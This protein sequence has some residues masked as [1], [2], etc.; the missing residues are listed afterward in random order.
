M[1]QSPRDNITFGKRFLRRYERWL[2]SQED[3][4]E[5]IAAAVAALDFAPATVDV[6]T[7]MY[8]DAVTI[9]VARTLTAKSHTLVKRDP[10]KAAALALLALRV[11]ESA[12]SPPEF[13]AGL[14]TAR[15]EAW[16]RY[17]AAVFETGNFPKAWRASERADMYFQLASPFPPAFRSETT[18]GLIQGMILHFLGETDRGL[19]RIEQSANLILAVFQEADKYVEAI[20]IYNAILM[21]A[22]RFEEAALRWQEIAALARKEGNSSTLA[23][24]VN[25]IGRCYL[26]LGKT[27]EALVC[28]KT[29]LEMF[30]QFG[31]LVEIPDVHLNLAYALRLNKRF[32]EAILEMYKCRADLAKFG[33]MFEAAQVS[34]RIVETQLLAHRDE[35]IP[36]VCREAADFFRLAGLPEEARRATECLLE[37]ART[38]TLRVEAVREISYLTQ[39]RDSPAKRGSASQ[40]GELRRDRWLRP[41]PRRPGWH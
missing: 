22:G 8:P 11:A 3:H 38:G 5:P 13:V 16:M 35:E 6:L 18:L 1:T 20:T 41:R 17:A 37:A 24:I 26:E 30:N 28:F 19:V 29:A 9:G 12:T 33:M 4:G 14:D 7:R 2:R 31:L 25:N 36:P 10:P 21:R 39:L 23:Y 15:G 34:I 27:D 40:S 32:A